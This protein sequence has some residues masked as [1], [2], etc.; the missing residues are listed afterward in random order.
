MTTRTGTRKI[1]L[2]VMI[3]LD[4]FIEDTGQ[5]IDWHNA[6]AEFNTFAEEQLNAIDTIIFGRKTYELMANYWPTAEALEEDTVI[7]GLM[8]ARQKI[9]F[10]TTMTKAGWHNTLLIKNN[11][12]TEVEKIKGLQGKDLIIFGSADLASTFQQLGLIDEYRIMVNPVVLGKG[13]P[14]FKQSNE[15]LHLRLIRT[16]RFNSGNVLLC[17]EPAGSKKQQTADK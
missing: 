4:G 12:L 3:S 13:T 14:L 9:V 7:S 10:S 15:R 2:F 17:Y 11:V 1:I 6:D 8:N 5:E 16:E